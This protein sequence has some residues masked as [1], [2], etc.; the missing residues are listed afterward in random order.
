MIKEFKENNI[1]LIRAD[2]TRPNE[3]INIFNLG[4]RPKV[5]LYEGLKKVIKN[6]FN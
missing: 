5:K 2:W 3:K 6:R 1:T 4:W